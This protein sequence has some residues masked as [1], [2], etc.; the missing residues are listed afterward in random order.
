MSKIVAIAVST[1]GP[2]ALQHVIPKLPADLDAPVLLVQH[3]L[4]GFTKD[5]AKRLGQISKIRVKEAVE[6]E[7]IQKGCVYLAR[8]G[9][10]MN[11]T[12]NLELGT[13]YYSDEPTR[14]GVKP[15]ADYLFESLINSSF[16]EIVCVVMTGMG[17]DATEGIIHLEKR[18]K[19]FVIAQ[20]SESC[21]VYGMPRSI[22][23][24]KRA[25]RIVPLDQ[26]AQEIILR[27][28]VRKDG[29]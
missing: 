22:V 9:K 8:G 6:Y 20:N 29:R 16:D 17:C 21:T 26:I 5:L 11:Y 14:Q 4:A 27:V 10:H 1:G 18:K 12:K 28:G 15:C 19:I 2:K 23:E 7:P 24:A 3:M 13:I 25:N